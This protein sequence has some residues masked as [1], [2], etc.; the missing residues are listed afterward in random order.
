M[1]PLEGRE[2][3]SLRLRQYYKLDQKV[4]LLSYTTKRS[5][6]MDGKDEND[7]VV[8]MLTDEDLELVSGGRNSQQQT[9]I[10]CPQCGGFI[11]VDI[12]TLLYKSNIMCPSCDLKICINK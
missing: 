6:I 8:Y 4:G 11:H 9:G 10:S 5:M 7:A 1:M 12:T 2:F 3:E